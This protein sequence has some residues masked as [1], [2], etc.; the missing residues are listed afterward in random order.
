MLTNYQQ[1]LDNNKTKIKHNSCDFIPNPNIRLFKIKRAEILHTTKLDF[2][3]GYKHG[4]KLSFLINH[5]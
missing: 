2:N 3:L 1:E 5:H 4:T